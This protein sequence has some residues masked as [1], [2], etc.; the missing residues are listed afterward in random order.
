MIGTILS[1][2]LKIIEGRRVVNQTKK[3][4]LI[5]YLKFLSTLRISLLGVAF[6]IFA[7]QIFVFATV[8]LV[9]MGIYLAPIENEVKIW[10]LFGVCAVTFLVTAGLM[11]FAFS[12][13]IWLKCS[14][15]SELIS[16]LD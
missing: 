8:G 9:V 10:I 13:R 4:G 3:I 11:A 7:F 6:L 14:G 15:A 2:I 5:Y 1:I 16:K 12:Q